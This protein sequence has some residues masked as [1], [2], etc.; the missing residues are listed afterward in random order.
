MHAGLLSPAFVTFSVYYH[1]NILQATNARVRRP[2]GN[3]AT[4]FK[5]ACMLTLHA[6]YKLA[7]DSVLIQFNSA[8]DTL[9]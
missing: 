3:K 1:V 9:A 7:I 4:Y 6:V 2:A 8:I 5:G